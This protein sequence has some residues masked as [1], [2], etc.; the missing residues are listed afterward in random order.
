MIEHQLRPLFGFFEAQ[1]LATGVY[2]SDREFVGG[3]LADE[4]ARARL[5]RAVTQFAPYLASAPSR[6]APEPAI[7]RAL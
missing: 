2:V 4:A 3:K 1:S 7:L 5:G 6:S